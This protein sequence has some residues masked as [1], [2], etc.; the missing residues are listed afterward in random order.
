MTDRVPGAPGQYIMTV[1]ASEAQ[2]ILTGEAVTVT[3]KRNDQ[4]L[5]EGTPYNK[6]A[7]LPDDLAGTICPGV[8]DPTPADA[9]NGL[10]SKRYVIVL[11][12]A[13]WS[14]NQQTAI[15]PSVTA[16][17]TKTDVYASPDPKDDNYAA[18]VEN[19]VRLY[20]QRDGA[21]VFK[22]ED[23]PEININVNVVVRV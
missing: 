9:F 8:S 23:V 1:E 5:V 11:G 21:V 18:Y 12:S 19:G 2:K 14:N 10:L 13:G 4:P 3:L 16:D 22:C 17:V 15:I 7:V 20:A 6:A